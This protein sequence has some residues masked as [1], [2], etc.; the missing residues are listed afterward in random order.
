MKNF[1]LTFALALAAVTASAQTTFTNGVKGST[2]TAATT[3]LSGSE[4]VY[5]IQSGASKT[6]TVSQVIAAATAQDNATTNGLAALIATNTT[7]DTLITNGLAAL[8]ATNGLNDVA[9]SNT[10]QSSIAANTTRDNVTSNYFNLVT[11]TNANAAAAALAANVATSNSIL[12]T[13][14][15]AAA[16]AVSTGVTNGGN[17]NFA[18]VTYA[19]KDNG[20][21]PFNYVVNLAAAS[22]QKVAFTNGSSGNCYVTVTN[23]AAGQNVTVLVVNTTGATKAFFFPNSSQNNVISGQSG[24]SQNIGN[25]KSVLFNFV[26]LDSTNVIMSWVTP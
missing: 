11:T 7:R 16:Q 25:N 3:P 21:S 12:A 18:N 4:S 15:A 22:F 5:L 10:L 17:G 13:A 23:Y 14:N 19:V 9:T 26:T 8:I 24:Q 1:I 2:L 6:A 20:Q